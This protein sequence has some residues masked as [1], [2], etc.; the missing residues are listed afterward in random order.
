MQS[1]VINDIATALTKLSL[2]KSELTESRNRA[3]ADVPTTGIVNCIAMRFARLSETIAS[4]L[5]S[6]PFLPES[7]NAWLCSMP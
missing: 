5:Y 6:V 2:T 1:P 3:L 7:L 4:T